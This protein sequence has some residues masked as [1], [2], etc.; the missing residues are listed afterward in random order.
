MTPFTVPDPQLSKMHRRAQMR[1]LQAFQLYMIQI[2]HG[3]KPQQAI[4]HIDEAIAIWGDYE[5]R[6]ETENPLPDMPDATGAMIENF[7]QAM[8]KMADASERRAVDNAELFAIHPHD[9]I[10][11]SRDM[12]RASRDMLA[13]AMEFA[14]PKS[15]EGRQEMIA[16]ELENRMNLV[17]DSFNTGAAMMLKMLHGDGRPEPWSEDYD[18]EARLAHLL[19]DFGLLCSEHD[20]HRASAS[21]DPTRQAN[22]GSPQ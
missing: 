18:H 4:E 8:K 1:M 19:S 15:L 9:I 16:H 10:E 5:D 22:G 7:Q 6:Y 20:N 12:A 2:A 21:T 13:P 14:L 17:M 3:T 11:A